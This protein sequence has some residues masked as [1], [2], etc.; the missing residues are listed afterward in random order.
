MSELPPGVRVTGGSGGTVA[1]LEDLERVAVHLQLAAGRLDEGHRAAVR[2]TATID[3]T[4][5]SS[6]LTASAADSA[7]APYRSLGAVAA[8]AAGLREAVRA[9]RSTYEHTDLGVGRL[10]RTAGVAGGYVIGE[11]GPGAWLALG[12]AVVAGVVGVAETVVIARVMRS[13]PT[14]VGRALRSVGRLG[15]LPGPVGAL[16]RS[17]AG[18]GLLPDWHLDPPT[19]Q[20]GVPALAGFALGALPGRAL[21]VPDPVPVAAATFADVDQ[22]VTRLSGGPTSLV[23]SRVPGTIV[24]PPPRTA[25]EALELVDEQYPDRGGLPGSVAVQQ[26]VH[27]DGSRSW[28]IAVPGT[29]EVVPGRSNPTDMRTNLR[30]VAGQ[31][32]DMSR[33]VEQ[34]MRAAGIR[35]DEPVLVVGH[36]QGGLVAARV[37]ADPA[38]Q[39]H[40]DVAAV[41]TAGSP[42]GGIDLPDGVQVMSLEHS[43]DAVPALDGRPN[44]DTPFRTTVER[45]LSRSADPRDRAAASPFGAHPLSVYERTARGLEGSDDPSVQGFTAALDRV[46]AGAVSA[47]TTIFQGVRTAR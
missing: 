10:M 8:R 22:A 46:L 47:R 17:L 20:A 15:D 5:R 24:G 45:D 18:P 13:S 43:Q 32:D 14:P 35:P 31:P 41:L 37:V 33:V 28:V 42:I 12:V 4:W 26:L 7:L 34:A 36:S 39:S 44:P 21:P 11:S 2:L 1:V 19:L 6:P 30:L 16:G 9:V 25:A 40:Y 3:E 27:E 38:I 23:V 29:Q